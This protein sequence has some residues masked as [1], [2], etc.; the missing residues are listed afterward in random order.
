MFSFACHADCAVLELVLLP[1]SYIF[2]ACAFGMTQ[3]AT[4]VASFELVTFW[5]CVVAVFAQRWFL[6]YSASENC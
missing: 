4:I 2:N 6:A 3:F 5:E 1:E